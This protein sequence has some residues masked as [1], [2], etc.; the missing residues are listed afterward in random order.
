MRI[1]TQRAGMPR[2]DF[3]QSF[4][5]NETNPDWFDSLAAS[6]QGW[7]EKIAQ[8]LGDLKR[9]QRRLIQIENEV[10][11]SLAEIKEVNRRLSIGEARA[12]RAKKEMVEAN[13]RLVISIA[14]KIHQP[15]LTVLGSYPGR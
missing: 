1:C 10:G 13:L 14:K 12:R 15:W 11:I 5:G 9:S 3:I 4:P 8:N 2:K 7:A 6:K